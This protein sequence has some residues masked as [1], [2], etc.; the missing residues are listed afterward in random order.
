MTDDAAAWSE[1]VIAVDV[2][3]RP[4]DVDRFVA[5]VNGDELERARFAVALPHRHDGGAQ[6]AAEAREVLGHGRLDV[7]DLSARCD[8]RVHDDAQE[9]ARD[10]GEREFRRDF[11]EDSLP[12]PCVRAGSH[13]D[14]CGQTAAMCPFAPTECGSGEFGHSRRRDPIRDLATFCCTHRVARAVLRGR[15]ASQ[16]RHCSVAKGKGCDFIVNVAS[17]IPTARF[18]A[19]L[20]EGDKPLGLESIFVKRVVLFVAQRH[21]RQRS[22]RCRVR[23]SSSSPLRPLSDDDVLDSLARRTARAVLVVAEQQRS[24]GSRREARCRGRRGQRH[25]A[26]QRSDQAAPLGRRPEAQGRAALDAP[27]SA[28]RPR[29][30]AASCSVVRLRSRRKPPPT[31]ST[32][33]IEAAEGLVP[34]HKFQRVYVDYALRRFGGNKVHTAAALGIDRRTIQRWARARAEQRP[35][36]TATPTTNTSSSS[37]T[38]LRPLRP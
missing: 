9:P 36:A 11:H 7:V 30:P 3:P 4:A 1:R 32:R 13:C 19:L 26:R 31:R 22:M 34:M 21:A 24:R 10:E 38:R 17:A 25:R 27:T 12:Q 23:T 2:E 16:S 37:S 29:R 18:S 33:S 15:H 35:V 8:R 14:D 28:S 20:V 6:R 5:I